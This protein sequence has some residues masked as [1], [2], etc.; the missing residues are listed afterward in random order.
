MI[1][2]AIQDEFMRP[3]FV[4][5]DKHIEFALSLKQ[6]WATLLVHRRK[7]I[8]IRSWPTSRRGRVLIH[9]AGTVD[10]RDAA[11]ELVPEELLEYTRLLG[12]IVGCGDITDC[13]T[14]AESETFKLDQNLHL[15]QPS[16]FKAPMYGFIFDNMKPLPF[17]K[18]PGWVRFFPVT[19]MVSAKKERPR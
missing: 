12:G 1:S 10:S 17:R 15:N 5:T 18:Y 4:E 19:E 7:S 11:W 3:I 9:A 8:E 16:W 6:P 2:V 14:Y 13:I